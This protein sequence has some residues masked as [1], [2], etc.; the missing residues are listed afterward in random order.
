MKA[1]RQSQI[2]DVVDH[3][4]VASQEALRQRLQ[5]RGIDATQATISRDLKELGLV[6]RAGDDQYRTFVEAFH[7]ISPTK[8]TNVLLKRGDLVR[9]VTPGGGGYGD[10]FRRDPDAVLADVRNGWVS[11]AAAQRDYGVVLEHQNGDYV[12]DDIAT[13]EL[14]AA[15][16]PAA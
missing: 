4:P 6:K 13:A 16:E 7:T 9:Y 14:R 1:W 3:E 8:F 5:T 15:R 10:P 11:P 12:V 2:L